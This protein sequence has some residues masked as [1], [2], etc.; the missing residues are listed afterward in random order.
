MQLISGFFGNPMRPNYVPGQ[1]AYLPNVHWPDSSFNINAFELNRSA[2]N[3]KCFVSS[4]CQDNCV[5]A[6]FGR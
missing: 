3:Q 4:V 2:V 1:P 5:H 6:I